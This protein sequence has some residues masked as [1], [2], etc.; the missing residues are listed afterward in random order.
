MSRHQDQTPWMKKRNPR[1]C[2]AADEEISILFPGPERKLQVPDQDETDREG[3]FCPVLDDV[4]TEAVLVINSSR[5]TLTH[6]SKMS[7]WEIGPEAQSICFGGGGACTEE[8][9]RGMGRPSSGAK[10]EHDHVVPTSAQEGDSVVAGDRESRAGDELQAD[11]PNLE[12]VTQDRIV[13]IRARFPMTLSFLKKELVRQLPVL[14]DGS[15]KI[16]NSKSAKV[17][18]DSQEL[19]RLL[20]AHG[21]LSLFITGRRSPTIV[22]VHYGFVHYG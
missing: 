2:A 6:G 18:E 4:V 13:Y 14:E 8:S 19:E 16:I 9:S 1:G 21:Q 15:V 11:P 10:Q 12:L 22:V 17:L 3:F 5:E 7:P 20:D